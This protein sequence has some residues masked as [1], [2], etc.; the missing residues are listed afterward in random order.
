ML[1]GHGLIVRIES[2]GC[3][4]DA[5]ELKE[6]IREIETNQDYE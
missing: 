2:S 3:L 4:N 5:S 6:R 1:T